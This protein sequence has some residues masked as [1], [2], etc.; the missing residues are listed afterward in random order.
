MSQVKFW[1][2]DGSM[3]GGG[4]F[5][6]IGKAFKS[7]YKALKNTGV[8]DK[9][10]Q[11]AL[12]KGRELGGQDH[13]RSSPRHTEDHTQLLSHIHRR[14]HLTSKRHQPRPRLGCTIR[15]K[16]RL[17][18]HRFVTPP[19]S[20]G[21]VSQSAIQVVSSTVHVLYLLQVVISK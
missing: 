7:V 4:F 10:K 11:A 17:G 20:K 21:V 14:P 1:V 3:Q 2:A 15:P 18:G 12:S 13:T 16:P 6:S 8:V 5:S 9:A 19:P